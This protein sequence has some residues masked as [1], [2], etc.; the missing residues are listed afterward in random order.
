METKRLHTD[1]PITDDWKDVVE[2]ILTQYV[3]KAAQAIAENA[4]GDYD[5]VVRAPVTFFVRFRREGDSITANGDV[6]CSC[7]KDDQVC[8]CYGTCPDFPDICDE[9][10]P[11][12][13]G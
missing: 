13:K 3:A 2:E 6:E 7:Y 11:L 1:S 9:I 10:P 5:V 8:V 12:K 4:P